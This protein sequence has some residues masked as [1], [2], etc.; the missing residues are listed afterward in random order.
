MS[1]R[2]DLIT[3]LEQ[4]NALRARLDARVRQ[5]SADEPAAAADPIALKEMDEDL[6]RLRHQISALDVEIAEL[7]RE[8]AGGA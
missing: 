4:K 6:D 3:Q 5:E 7:E 2:L 8:I 1:D